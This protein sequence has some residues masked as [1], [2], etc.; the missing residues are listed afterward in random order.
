MLLGWFRN[1]LRPERRRRQD[2]EKSNQQTTDPINPSLPQTLSLL[3]S[4]L[5]QGPDFIIRNFS[6]NPAHAGHLAVCYIE[7]LIDQNLLSDLMEGLIT[8]KLSESSSKLGEN[9]TV[10]LLKKTIPAGNIQMIHSQNEVYQAILS[11]NAV[12]VINGNNYAL[13]VSIA[14]GVRR[15]IQEPSTQTV[16]RGP[17]EGFTEDVS[18]NIT[19]IRR[20]L[21]TPDL[22]F[23]SHVIGRYTQ[24]KVILAYI[25]NVANPSNTGNYKTASIH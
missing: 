7:G 23:E 3:K 19:L 9:S 15:A 1:V 2:S 24:T 11:G 25:E 18:T 12:I 4:K 17:K 14:G 20:K 21:R 5:G 6:E 13:A 22:K 8:E 16:V 10:S